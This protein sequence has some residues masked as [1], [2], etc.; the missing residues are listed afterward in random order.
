MLGECGEDAFIHGDY[1][2]GL[3]TEDFDVALQ[4]ALGL[5]ATGPGGGRRR[6]EVYCFSG[7]VG[8]GPLAKGGFLIGQIAEGGQGCEHGI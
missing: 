1:G 4:I 8:H 6:S 5:L 2:K 7:G 3:L